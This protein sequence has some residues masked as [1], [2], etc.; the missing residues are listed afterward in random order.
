MTIK[1]KYEVMQKLCQLFSS[2]KAFINLKSS[3]LDIKL[4]VEDGPTL[5]QHMATFC[6]CWVCYQ[7]QLIYT[8]EGGVLVQYLKLPA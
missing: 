1:L 4:H 8:Q 3:E 7:Q 6:A 5:A 2:V